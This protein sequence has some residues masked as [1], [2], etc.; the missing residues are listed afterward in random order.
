[1]EILVASSVNWLLRPEADGGAVAV[2]LA[3]G[4]SDD[5]TAF[6]AAREA[7]LQTVAVVGGDNIFMGLTASAPAGA[8]REQAKREHERSTGSDERL[9]TIG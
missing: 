9:K 4:V 3:P 2:G 7:V 5:L 6:R 8:R 1:M